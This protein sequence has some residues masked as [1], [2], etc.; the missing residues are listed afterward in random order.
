MSLRRLGL[1]GGAAIVCGGAGWSAWVATRP[2]ADVAAGPAQDIWAHVEGPRKAWVPVGR[3]DAS[4]VRE[5]SGLVASRKHPGIFWTHGDSFTARAIFA[6]TE[7]GNI[8]AR[9]N[10]DAPNID[11]EDIATDDQGHL[12][13][14]DIGNNL[15][16][17]AERRIYKITEPDPYRDGDTTVTPVA[18]YTYS[19]PGK[20]FDAEGLFVHQGR[21]YLV[22]RHD[23]NRARVYR[24]TPDERGVLSLEEVAALRVYRASGADVSP[25]GSLLAVCTV[26]DTWVYQVD[27][28]MRPVEGVRP[29]FVRYPYDQ[30][31]ACCF[32]G[33]DLMLSNEKGHI[34]RVSA[35]D[36]Q[37]EVV[38]VP[39]GLIG[40]K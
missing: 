2:L 12:Y 24:L 39:P 35:A 23:E 33:A 13:I 11:W 5:S 29:T 31:E 9:I 40:T 34:F 30:V 36:M 17:L 28:S 10:L 7:N 15:R 37:Q 32:D 8:V 6:V 20:R 25:D 16:L 26:R 18:V 27:E 14:A 22:S 21:M 19:Y 4:V 3:M 1:L 38:F